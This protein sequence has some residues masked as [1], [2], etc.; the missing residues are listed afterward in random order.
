MVVDMVI[1][2]SNQKNRHHFEKPTFWLWALGP[3][4]FKQS[5]GLKNAPCLLFGISALTW[6]TALMLICSVCN[7]DHPH[8]CLEDLFK[9]FLIP[10]NFIWLWQ[11]DYNSSIHYYIVTSRTMRKQPKV[12]I[13][14]GPGVYFNTRRLCQAIKLSFENIFEAII[15]L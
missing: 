3:G 6:N 4:W 14:Q 8:R 5:K 1:N 12:N 15:V 10:Q 11:I 7:F 2:A 9:K 13:D